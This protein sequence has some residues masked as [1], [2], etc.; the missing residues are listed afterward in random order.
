MRILSLNGKKY[1]SEKEEEGS[2]IPAKADKHKK[3]G[4]SQV[5]GNCRERGIRD[6]IGLHEV[7]EYSS[8]G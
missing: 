7:L 8:R 2:D 1:K 6:W 5:R 4:C 3:R